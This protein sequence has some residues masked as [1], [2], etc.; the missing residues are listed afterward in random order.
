MLRIIRIFNKQSSIRYLSRSNFNNDWLNKAKEI[1]GD[2]NV[3]MVGDGIE[4][5]DV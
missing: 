3:K 2:D 1:L 5:V 4:A